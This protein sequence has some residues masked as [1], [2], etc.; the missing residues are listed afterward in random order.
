MDT[1]DFHQETLVQI[2]EFVE[3]PNLDKFIN[4]IRWENN[5]AIC[6][7]FNS[8][9]I[10]EAFNDNSFMSHAPIPPDQ[11]NSDS[12]N[13]YDPSSTLSSFSCFDGEAKEGEEEDNMG[14]SSATTTTTT[15]IKND[16]TKPRPKPDRSKTLVSERRRRNRMKEKL[17]ALRSLVPNITKMDKASIIGDAVSYMHELQAQAK[18]LKAEVQGLETSLMVS[19]SYQG[20]IENP[21]KVQFI[22][23]I[24]AISKKINQMDMFQ[25]DEKGFYVKIVCNKGEGV[26][27]SLYRSLESL[28][29]F[30]VQNSNMAT[31]SDSFLLTFSLNAKGR[32]PEINLYNLKLWL[33]EAFVNQGF[34]FTPFLM[35]DSFNL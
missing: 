16:N 19:K 2:N 13:V 12:V 21:M 26:A 24:R 14:D 29:A 30:N 6:N 7:N 27:A 28:T 4:L 33:T 10:N 9:L 22:N 1:M 25:V 18:M 32:E 23:N 31:V 34:E 35:L 20:S 11:C 17:Y 3:D 8:E 5:D 15:E